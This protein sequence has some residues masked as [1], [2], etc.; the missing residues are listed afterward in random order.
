[1][2]E[3]IAVGALEASPPR[4]IAVTS[5]KGGVGKSNVTANLALAFARRGERVCIFDAD[6]GLANVDVLFG[7]SPHRSLLHV[8]RGECRLAD[9]IIEGPGGVKIVPAASGFSELTALG[10]TERLGLLAEVDALDGAFDVLLVD[11]GAGISDNVLYFASAAAEA[12]VVI[13]PEPT[14]ITD[15]Y[16]LI[17]VL[18]TRHGRRDFLVLVNMAAN[19]T[20]AQAAFT[21]LARVA[22]RFLRVRVEYAG[23]IPFDDAVSQAVCQQRPLLLTAP[24]T[25]ASQ[26]IGRLAQRLAARPVAPVTGGMQFFFQRLIG[27]GRE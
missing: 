27:E 24:G 14:A 22:A 2:A 15:A 20:D 21:R 18:A 23:Y 10:A 3:Q 7:L 26:A 8:L 4:V 1:M 9:V 25:S 16:A 13:T 12:L 6:L 19:A 5:G 11:T 17:K